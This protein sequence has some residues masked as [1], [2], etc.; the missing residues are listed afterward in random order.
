MTSKK[1]EIESYGKIR[2]HSSLMYLNLCS[3]ALRNDNGEQTERQKNGK[4][5]ERVWKER[6]EDEGAAYWGIGVHCE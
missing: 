6:E 1:L 2:A 3:K 4:R 5:K